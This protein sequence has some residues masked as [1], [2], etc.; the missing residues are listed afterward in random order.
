MGERKSEQISAAV[1]ARR[2]ALADLMHSPAVTKGDIARAVEE[3]TETAASCLAVERTSVWRIVEDGAALECLDLYER[4]LGKHS[5][6]ATIRADQMPVYFA[7]LEQER[8]IS[9][10]DAST[11]PRTREFRTPYLRQHLITAMLA[12]PVFVRGKMVGV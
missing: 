6:G 5:S 1:Y 2:K 11:D 3:I 8:T 4:S 9:A 10:N 7:A 12:A